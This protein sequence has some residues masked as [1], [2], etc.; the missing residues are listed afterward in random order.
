MT[1]WDPT[2]LFTSMYSFFPL[3]LPSE[4]HRNG[5]TTVT[6]PV[7]STLELLHNKSNCGINYKQL[8]SRLI[9]L[10]DLMDRTE[11][12]A[13]PTKIFFDLTQSL[14]HDRNLLCDLS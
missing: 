12:Y 13:V 7:L 14:T 11:N 10:S 2:T 6:L 3:A 9:D 5:T 1:I 8:R 4:I